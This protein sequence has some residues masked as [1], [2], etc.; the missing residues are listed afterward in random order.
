MTNLL[1]WNVPRR[2]S[3]V[4]G[5]LGYAPLATG[6]NNTPAATETLVSAGTLT[7][8]ANAVVLLHVAYA[9]S[10]GLFADTPVSVTGFGLSW[11]A[12]GFAKPTG[13]ST[14]SVALYVAQG[15]AP[16]SAALVVEFGYLPD[17][18]TFELI[19]V[20][21]AQVGNGGLDSILQRQFIHTT[22]NATSLQGWIQDSQHAN[23][24][25]LAFHSVGL[26]AQTLAVAAGETDWTRITNVVGA[27]GT[28]FSLAALL[29]NGPTDLSPKA[30]WSGSGS[31]Q[32]I[33]VEI[34]AS[35][36]TSRYP[37]DYTN[38]RAGKGESSANTTSH[39]TGSSVHSDV[40]LNATT[41]ITSNTANFDASFVGASITGT[42]IPA[43]TTIL[44]VNAN[45]RE[46]TMSQAATGS[47]TITATI[48]GRKTPFTAGK[49]YIMA[50]EATRSTA[51]QVPSSV[52]LTGG[53]AFTLLDSII[54]DTL[55]IPSAADTSLS[56][57]KFT[58]SSTVEDTV[59][60]SFA[61][62]TT[63]GV[64]WGIVQLEGNGAAVNTANIVKTSST[65]ATT[66]PLTM[67]A[68]G[69][70]RNGVMGVWARTAASGTDPIPGEGTV[71]AIDQSDASNRILAI[72]F[73]HSNIA[74]P[75]LTFG[76]SPVGAIAIELVGA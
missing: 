51:G 40:V 13:G 53:G 57:W 21:G 69:S 10:G 68:Y 27:A 34:R 66:L 16:S 67:G 12:V 18:V 8:T 63:H 55:S 52:A 1:L 65:S 33:G 39:V 29:R 42:N 24:G 28:A 14:R 20:T 58:A 56:V 32:Y 35:G 49:S 61:N 71:L 4:I 3:T 6:S 22:A 9:T 46:A 25:L 73:A 7:P 41:T 45:G 59:S 44:S 2:R 31:P 54:F 60:F 23:N 5:A 36:A 70:P 76:T 15:A 47:G 43:S 37:L 11:T 30:S 62:A 75:N 50:I 19:E 26:D 72:T 38:L 64:A 74:T 48:T 17:D